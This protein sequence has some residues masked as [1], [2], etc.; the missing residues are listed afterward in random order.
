[1]CRAALLWTADFLAHA[2]AC[3]SCFRRSLQRKLQVET[4]VAVVAMQQE[5]E[6]AQVYAEHLAI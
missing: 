5:H 6:V 4:P 1:M 2:A 3:W